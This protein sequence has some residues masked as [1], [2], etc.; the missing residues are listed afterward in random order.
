V[1]DGGTRDAVVGRRM[2][3]EEGGKSL[4]HQLEGGGHTLQNTR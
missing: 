4:Y 3:K 2:E 1:E